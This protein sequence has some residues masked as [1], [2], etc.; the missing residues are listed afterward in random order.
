[1]CVCVCVCV[2]VWFWVCTL[3]T[4]AKIRLLVD[5]KSQPPLWLHAWRT[6]PHIHTGKVGRMIMATTG[7]ALHGQRGNPEVEDTA[8]M[9]DMDMAILAAPAPAYDQYAAQIAREYAHVGH[10]RFCAPVS[11]PSLPCCRTLCHLSLLSLC[12]TSPFAVVFFPHTITSHRLFSLS[13]FLF[14]SY[15]IAQAILLAEHVSCAVS[16]NARFSTRSSSSISAK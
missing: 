15:H 3:S 10:G 11:V 2:R 5:G 13:F 6:P 12:S 9:L 14:E 16:W 8:L 4:I 7:H 1:V